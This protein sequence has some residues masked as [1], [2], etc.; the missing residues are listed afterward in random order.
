MSIEPQTVKI[1]I[2]E[3]KINIVKDALVLNEFFRVNQEK[4]LNIQYD[5]ETA[6]ITF[7]KKYMN[8]LSMIPWYVTLDLSTKAQI[9]LILDAESNILETIE[10]PI[11]NSIQEENEV[12]H[13]LLKF[14]DEKITPYKKLHPAYLPAI[15]LSDKSIKSILENDK[16]V[17]YLFILLLGI[18]QRPIYDKD[19]EF[20]D[21]ISILDSKVL[22]NDS[23]LLLY[24]E[25]ILN[26]IKINL[27][28]HNLTSLTH[29]ANYDFVKKYVEIKLTAINK[30]EYRTDIINTDYDIYL[31]LKNID[32][33]NIIENKSVIK[34]IKILKNNNYN[35]V[36]D[37]QP[38][39]CNLYNI[40]NEI[41]DISDLESNILHTLVLPPRIDE[42][43]YEISLRDV[44][45]IEVIH[46][47]LKTRSCL[48]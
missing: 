10:D 23:Q 42:R 7:G 24:I 28:K 18:E 17:K 22:H 9:D 21:F 37:I 15:K 32:Y 43:D 20:F 47:I 41:F 31:L 4:S 36:S 38:Y 26:E 19:T 45:S 13:R 12:T 33:A 40:N 16:L 3:M 46:R 2:K 34:L 1:D 14:Y 25:Y 48:E 6:V 5:L 29:H 35:I 8:Y 30:M 39:E 44:L 11:I 27:S